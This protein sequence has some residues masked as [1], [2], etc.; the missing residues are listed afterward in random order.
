MGRRNFNPAEEFSS[1]AYPHSYDQ[2]IAAPQY[3]KESETGY[4][5]AQQGYN[6]RQNLAEQDYL[7]EEGNKRGTAYGN[8][9]INDLTSRLNNKRAALTRI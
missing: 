2:L 8:Q 5:Q 3:F 9:Q 1:F 6:Q 7:R 4:N